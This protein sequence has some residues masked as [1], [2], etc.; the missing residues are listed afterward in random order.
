MALHN[1]VITVVDGGKSTSASNGQALSTQQNRKNKSSENN[2]PS[3]MHKILNYNET[4]KN[5]IEKKTNATTAYSA[6]MSYQIAKQ[7]VM[8]S[9]NFYLSDI[10]RRNGDSNYQSQI[11]RTI[12]IVEDG[13]GIIG[14]A[15]GGAAAGAA[16]GPIGMVVGALAGLI[17]ST[18]G[19]SFKYAERQRAYQHEMFK[20]NT[21]Q[22]Y[23]LARANYSAFTGRAR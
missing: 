6:E 17:S 5:W 22:A 21:S 8:D 13:L 19:T 14:G 1:L 9:V 20:E 10:G 2:E 7:I 11:N 15:F 4:A 23:N 12:E 3:L 18:I 16:A